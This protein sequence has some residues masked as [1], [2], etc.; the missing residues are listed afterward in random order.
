LV[1]D[2]QPKTGER[3]ILETSIAVPINIQVAD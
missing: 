1:A 2:Y 3:I